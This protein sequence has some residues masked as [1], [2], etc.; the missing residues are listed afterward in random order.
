VRGA[1][2]DFCVRITNVVRNAMG[3]PNSSDIFS[4]KPNPFTKA[5]SPATDPRHR[6]VYPNPRLS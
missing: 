2:E 1:E 4:V 6:G 5:V 3:Y